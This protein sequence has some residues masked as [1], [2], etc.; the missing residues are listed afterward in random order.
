VIFFAPGN[1]LKEAEFTAD[2]TRKGIQEFLLKYSAPTSLSSKA[3]HLDHFVTVISTHSGSAGE[4]YIKQY[5][6]EQGWHGKVIWVTNEEDE[7]L[8]AMC[9]SDYGIIYDGQMV[10][11]AAACHLPTMNLLQMR[12][13]HIWYNNLFNRWWNDMNII[14]D[15]HVYPEL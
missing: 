12:M 7:H 9:A 2:S 3:R 10:S 6:K 4:Q 1:E 5:V 13:H 15:N 11:S 14:A 8:S